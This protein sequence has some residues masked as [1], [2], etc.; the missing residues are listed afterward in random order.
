MN[1]SQR[2]VLDDKRNVIDAFNPGRP[3][4]Y[5]FFEE[6]E[7]EIQL[8]QSNFLVSLE[9]LVDNLIE[10]RERHSI[11][12][13]LL[14]LVRATCLHKLDPFVSIEKRFAGVLK[15]EQIGLQAFTSLSLFTNDVE[16]LLCDL[17]GDT[18][19]VDPVVDAVYATV[20]E[21]ISYAHPD[22]W[23]EHQDAQNWDYIWG[24]GLPE[25]Y[26][27]SGSDHGRGI[28]G[29]NNLR[30][31]AR[32]VIAEPSSFGKYTQIFATHIVN[33]IRMEEPPQLDLDGVFSLDSDSH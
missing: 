9:D 6:P 30:L 20:E 21:L 17:Y 18:P 3:L 25:G 8:R 11:C 23:Q 1:T 33:S 2:F 5:C 24:I 22:L 27:I 12:W 29:V 31:R 16:R 13:T 32:K 4:P 28:Q 15:R 26:G 10:R 14:W 19:E 7:T